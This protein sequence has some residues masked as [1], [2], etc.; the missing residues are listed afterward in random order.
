M[1]QAIAQHFDKMIAFAAR[2]G[3]QSIS[4]GV[5]IAYEAGRRIGVI[6]GMEQSKKAL[7]E[8]NEQAEDKEKAL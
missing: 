6:Q 1:I 7:L 2:Q 8:F 5:D 4:S 3:M